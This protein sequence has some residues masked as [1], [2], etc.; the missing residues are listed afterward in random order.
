MPVG[1]L[2]TVTSLIVCRY[3][4]ALRKMSP[5]TMP[6]FGTEPRLFEKERDSTVRFSS[7]TLSC[8]GIGGMGNGVGVAVLLGRKMVLKPLPS[9]LPLKSARGP[10]LGAEEVNF[11]RA[12]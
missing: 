1:W 7:R 11:L 3:G 10:R 2:G 6:R 12:V 9:K 8:G 4:T 5:C